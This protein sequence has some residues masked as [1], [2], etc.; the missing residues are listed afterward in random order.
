M[1]INSV[2]GIKICGIS[3][4]VST[5]YVKTDDYLDILGEHTISSFKKSAGVEGRY[6]ALPKQTAG[7]LCFAAAENLLEKKKINKKEIGSLVLVTQSPDYGNPSTACVLQGR[8]GLPK[9]CM[10]FDINLGCS[11]YA[12]GLNVASS[13]LATSDQKYALLLAGDTK[14]CA[15][16]PRGGLLYARCGQNKLHDAFVGRRRNGDS[17]GKERRCEG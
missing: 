7:D 11:G 12:Y 8:L 13:L 2:K 3:G 16:H 5:Q 6:L 15:N 1:A 9:S 10:A 14:G 17:F 4:A